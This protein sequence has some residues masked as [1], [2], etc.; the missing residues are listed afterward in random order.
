MKTLSIA[1]MAAFMLV[2]AA[3]STGQA[4]SADEDIYNDPSPGGKYV[5]RGC[6]L[7][8]V[9]LIRG[10]KLSDI[11]ELTL[12][13]EVQGG[14]NS[15]TTRLTFPILAKRQE[16]NKL[17]LDYQWPPAGDTYEATIIG[18]SLINRKTK[19]YLAGVREELFTRE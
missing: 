12:I 13:I 11:N 18:G 14:Q 17:I 7:A 3:T 15:H 4:Q 1:L 9:I 10:D 19:G 6:N 5:Y 8:Q 2:L 16:G